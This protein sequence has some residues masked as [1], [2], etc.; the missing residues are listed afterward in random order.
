MITMTALEHLAIG[1]ESLEH[2][3]TRPDTAAAEPIPAGN[4]TT[5]DISGTDAQILG[6]PSAKRC[7]AIPTRE[8]HCGGSPIHDVPAR[9]HRL[10]RSPP[11]PTG[12]A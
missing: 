10:Q 3:P 5:A 11:Q 2:P 8:H 7:T 6:H 1:A 12:N 4:P 9:R